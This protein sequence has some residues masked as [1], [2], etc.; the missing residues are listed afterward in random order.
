MPSAIPKYLIPDH[1][2]RISTQGTHP[3]IIRTGPDPVLTLSAQT[4]SCHRE[5]LTI[6]YGHTAH[7]T[8]SVMGFH[9]CSWLVGI[10]THFL[11]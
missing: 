1:P 8:L 3:F 2:A 4:L 9:P 11:Y 5:A 6:L 10:L 7:D